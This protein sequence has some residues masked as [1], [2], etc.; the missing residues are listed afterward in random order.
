VPPNNELLEM[1]KEII[2]EQIA[3]YRARAQEYDASLIGAGNASSSPAHADIFE[4]DL[5][6]LA[7]LL[8]QQ[9]PYEQAL[10]LACGTG[11]WTGTLLTIA[12]H[13]TALDAAPEMLAIARRKHG[14]EH[15]DYQQAN[16]FHWQP[17]Q[18]YDLVFFAFWLSHV[19][20]DA[21]DPFLASASRAVKPG[22]RLIII[23]QYAPLPGDLAVA[24]DDLYAERPLSDGRTF[25][26][27]KVFYDLDLL[28]R[29]LSNLG[30]EVHVEAVGN[31]FFFLTATNQS[32]MR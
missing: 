4:G 19:P 24:K 15:I 2:D 18:Q 6:R 31:S 3:Y 21:L 9:G 11:I 25:T 29:K 17:A 22:G 7:H 23:D 32:V 20:P 26:I 30:F 1:K 8:Q 12:R 14:D 13:V 28:R 27:V 16:L 10:E 5:A